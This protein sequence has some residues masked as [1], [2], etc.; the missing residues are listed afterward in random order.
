MVVGDSS[1]GI[2][3]IV[4]VDFAREAED[5]ALADDLTEAES[6][7]SLVPFSRRG[8]MLFEALGLSDLSLLPPPGIFD[9]MEPRMDR[10][11]SLVSVRENEG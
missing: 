11:E 3:E 1:V 10:V 5:L 8:I 4:E 7:L 2:E 9:R 6:A